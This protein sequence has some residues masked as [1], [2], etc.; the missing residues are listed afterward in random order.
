MAIHH[1]N[2]GEISLPFLDSISMADI[3]IKIDLKL[4]GRI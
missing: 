4:K 2:T 1:W 3:E